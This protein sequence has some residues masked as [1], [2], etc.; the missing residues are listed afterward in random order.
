MGT[1]NNNYLLLKSRDHDVGFTSYIKEQ[2][3]HVCFIIPLY[4]AEKR[5][6]SNLLFTAELSSSNW[7]GDGQT[8]S[9]PGVCNYGF[10]RLASWGINL[11]EFLSEQK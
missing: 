7:R 8:D 5:E 9:A 2:E 3:R 11:K 4:K 10:D 6:K 1:Q